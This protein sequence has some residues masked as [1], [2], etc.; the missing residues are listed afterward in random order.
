MQGLE[1]RRVNRYRAAWFQDAEDLSRSD[2]RFAK[3][4]ENIQ[5]KDSV[6]NTIAEREVMCV[7][8]DVGVAEDPVLELDAFRKSLGRTARADVQDEVFSFA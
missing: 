5:R 3:V 2:F 6:E 1:E 7:A 4:F 8:D